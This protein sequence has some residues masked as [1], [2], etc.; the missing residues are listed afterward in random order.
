MIKLLEFTYILLLLFYRNG[1]HYV[2][3]TKV[4]ITRTTKMY[5]LQM[6]AC[7]SMIAFKVDFVLFL[8]GQQQ[9]IVCSLCFFIN[10]FIKRDFK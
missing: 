2:C 1:E 9:A 6:H 4:L 7:R 3:S 10:K 8:Y 5:V